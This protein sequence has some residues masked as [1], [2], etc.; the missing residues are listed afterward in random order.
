[1][2]RRLLCCSSSRLNN[3]AF[4]CDGVG[5]GSDT[6]AKLFIGHFGC[7]RNVLPA[8]NEHAEFLTQQLQRLVGN[9]ALILKLAR[10]CA[11]WPL[12]L[13]HLHGPLNVLH[14]GF[15]DP[16]LSKA[17]S[18]NRLSSRLA[19]QGLAFSEEFSHPV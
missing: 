8:L 18:F 17:R 10:P 16:L 19:V 1:M 12:H 2:R 11:I 14:E 5:D 3:S 15:D 13:C 7:G 9:V 4:S 6:L